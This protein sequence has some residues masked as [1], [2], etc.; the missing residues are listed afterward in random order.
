MDVKNS[1]QEIP[2]TC[3]LVRRAG[4]QLSQ[5]YDQCLR[6]AGIRA[7]QYSMLRCVVEHPDPFISD[8]GRS[9]GMD[10]TT[11]TRNIK[12]LEKSGLVETKLHPGDPRKIQVSLSSN[13]KAKLTECHSLWEKAQRRVLSSMGKDNLVSL[14]E[15]LGKLAQAVG[16]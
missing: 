3:L 16:Q 2:C 7:T 8:I 4:R 12:K 15:L 10:Q 5:M 13:G 6:P 1:I 14:F 9:L 11:V